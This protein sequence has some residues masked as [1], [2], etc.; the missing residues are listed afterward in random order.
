VTALPTLL[1]EGRERL[2]RELRSH[3]H[4]DGD[5]EHAGVTV[6]DGDGTVVATTAPA[7]LANAAAVAGAFRSR[8][9]ALEPGDAA[10]TNDPFSGSPHLQDHW[11]GVP[12]GQ[13]TP[14]LVLAH[15]HLADVGGQCAGGLWPAAAE[16]WQEGTRTTPVRLRRAGRV[17]RDL[18]DIA[19]LN[20]RLPDLIEH[21][22][23][24]LLA[25]ATDVAE[26]VAP[27][28]ARDG[29]RA[30][31]HAPL[32]G[33]FPRGDAEA[34]A[35]LHNCAGEDL[36]VS[37]R[38]RSG[39]ERLVVDL[40]GSSPRPERGFVCS[41]LP[42]TRSAVAAAVAAACGRTVDAGLLASLDV[43]APAGSVVAGEE[44]SAVGWSP[45][46]TRAAVETA[47][48]TA[49]AG[50]TGAEPRLPAAHVPSAAG[51]E[52]CGREGCPF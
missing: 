7:I 47:V 6:V 18:L 46:G 15:A 35:A 39:G 33:I 29:A 23:L 31:G 50:L 25:V 13:G 16:I 51:V 4:G 48:G 44:P 42:S 21:D 36:V 10:L 1:E 14:G 27:A 11:V 3:A 52:G 19:R 40:A 24:A 34:S 20:S 30:N 26:R 2:V 38:V 32:A 49:L 9:G 37:A 17:R 28:T 12:C 45:Y 8:L 5:A 22:L 43:R 41:P